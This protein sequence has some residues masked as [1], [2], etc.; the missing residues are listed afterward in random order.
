[1]TRAEFVEALEPH[2]GRPECT[3]AWR[4]LVAVSAVDAVCDAGWVVCDDPA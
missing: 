1:M 2:V 4:R 3:P